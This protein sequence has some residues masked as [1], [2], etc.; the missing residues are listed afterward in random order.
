MTDR[1]GWICPK[2]EKANAPW[3]PSCSCASAKK[4]QG[5]QNPGPSPRDLIP[6]NPPPEPWRPE[7]WPRYWLEDPS[8]TAPLCPPPWEIICGTST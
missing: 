2:C 4:E 8:R 5:V 3:V 1:T 7:P 6:R